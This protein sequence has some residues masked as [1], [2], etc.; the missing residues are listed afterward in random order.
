MS[1][2]HSELID[3]IETGMFLMPPVPG[4]LRHLDAPGLRGRVSDFPHPF[5]NMVGAARFESR[6]HAENALQHVDELFRTEGLPYSWLTGTEDSPA[7]LPDVL[8]A[9]GLVP[10]MEMAG[11]ALTDLSRPVAANPAVTVRKLVEADVP[12]VTAVLAEGFEFPVPAAGL[13]MASYRQPEWQEHSDGYLACVE[14]TAAPVAAGFSVYV[15]GTRIVMLAG[16]ATLPA[17]RGRGVYTSLLARRLEDAVARGCEAAVIQAVRTTSAPIC[18][19][20]GFEEL[21]ALRL[22]MRSPV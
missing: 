8:R 3:A 14:E 21:S 5:L 13:M 18:A 20:L 4:R 22:W 9:D 16:A 6:T 10:I 12:A 7:D 1:A 17:Y 2:T 19:K 11:M 15:P